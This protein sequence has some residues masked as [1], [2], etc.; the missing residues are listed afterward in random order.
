MAEDLQPSDD[1]HGNNSERPTALHLN[2]NDS[3]AAASQGTIMLHRAKSLKGYKLDSKDG[4]IG[5]VKEFYFDDQHWAIRYMVVDTAAWLPGRQVLISPY[6]LVAAIEKDQHIVV[7]LTQRQ[8]EDSPS[9]EHDKPV[10]RQFEEAYHGYYG[11]PGYWSGPH[12]WGEQDQLVR[13]STSWRSPNEGGKALD[14]HLRSTHTVSGYH[15]QATDGEI[16]HV[17]D[18]VI[19]DHTW[20]IRYLIV[21]TRNWMPG[22][23]VLISVQWIDRVSWTESKVYVGISRE[24][25]RHSPEYTESS[26]LSRDYE[27]TLYGHYDRR[28]YW[29][30]EELRVPASDETPPGVQVGAPSTLHDRS[31]ENHQV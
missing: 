14:H 6:A 2:V 26:L 13:D 21:S 27:T 17:D 16:G 30:E 24:N 12:M 19:D 8:I 4:E 11:W 31:V 23:R 22:K 20:A 25:V 7:N 29:V 9:L 15:V 5:R 1:A 3:W 18:F 10:S 28:G